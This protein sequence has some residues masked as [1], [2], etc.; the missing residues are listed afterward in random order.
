MPKRYNDSQ[1]PISAIPPGPLPPEVRRA[2]QLL[3]SH[4]KPGSR[5]TLK[6]P[7]DGYRLIGH[8][9]VGNHV[10]SIGTVDAGR[11]AISDARLEQFFQFAHW[12]ASKQELQAYRYDEYSR[13][14]ERLTMHVHATNAGGELVYLPAGMASFKLSKGTPLTHSLTV[15]SASAA[16]KSTPVSF[17][18]SNQS[19]HPFA[20]AGDTATE[21]VQNRLTVDGVTLLSGGHY[22]EGAAN[23]QL[24]EQLANGLGNALGAVAVGF[25]Y[26]QYN[27]IALHESEQRLRSTMMGAQ[28]TKQSVKLIV[29]YHMIGR[30]SYEQLADGVPEPKDFRFSP[31]YTPSR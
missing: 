21:I 25:T 30:A 11:P 7:K 22:E 16:S 23:W 8:V 20:G 6:L 27:G 13:V 14:F 1:D 4:E 12:L 17:V 26:D 2:A 31:M 29:P 10:I 28:P 18:T 15:G 5:V 19:V 24:G 3:L 9:A